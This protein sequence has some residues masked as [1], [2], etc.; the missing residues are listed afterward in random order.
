[1]TIQSAYALSRD[2][3]V[4]SLAPGKYA[5]FIVLLNDPLE[6][7]P[8]LLAR[9]RVQLTVVGGQIEYCKSTEADL[10]PG[11]S[12]RD[13]VRLP[14]TRPPVAVRWL[15]AVLLISLPLTAMLLRRRQAAK[16]LLLGAWAGIVAGIIWLG[17]LIASEW[18]DDDSFALIMIPAFLMANRERA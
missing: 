18:L 13:P 3:E 14:D 11:F 10:C 2:S 15:V 9:N 4:G 8:N 7:E 5:D 12:N 17:F 16:V 1:M 6:A